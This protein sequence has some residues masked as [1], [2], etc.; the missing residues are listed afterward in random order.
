MLYLLELESDLGGDCI[1]FAKQKETGQPTKRLPA[2]DF[3]M[4]VERERGPP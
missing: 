4:V 3:E 2:R 1:P